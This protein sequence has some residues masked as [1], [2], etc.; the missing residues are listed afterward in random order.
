MS[1]QTILVNAQAGPHSE[2]I[3]ACAARLAQAGG[4][5]GNAHL[6]G[7]ASTG[8]NE[9]V[10][11]CNAAAPGVALLPDDLGLFQGSARQALQ[12]FSTVVTR[13]GIDTP[14]QRLTDDNLL[15]SLALQAR[16]ADLVVV[17][18]ETDP[19]S[20]EASAGAFAPQDLVLHCP[21]PVVVVPAA[22]D[23]DRAGEGVGERFG[24]HIVLAWDGGM[25][26]SRAVEA[27]LPLLR[28]AALVTLAVFNPAGLYNAHGPLP[29]ADLATYLARHGVRI[30]I[31]VRET[32]GHVSDALLGLCGET[33][34]DLLVMGCYGHARWRELLLG[35]VSRAILR[36]MTLPV[37]MAH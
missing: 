31:V 28:Q 13:L 3:A 24:E 2:R 17:G 27:A 18:Q 10:Y 20:L 15:A 7:L 1:Y 30:E 4:T 34:A 21:R 11:Q 25:A 35:G 36:D 26:A 5:G 22:A 29:G 32:D 8:L 14:E 9:L 19:C 37:L 23:G 12:A 6:V 33:G 16:Y